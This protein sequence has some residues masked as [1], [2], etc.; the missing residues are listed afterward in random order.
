MN[1][2]LITS[3]N[4]RVKNIQQVT[5]QEK[6]LYQQEVVEGNKI[7]DEVVINQTKDINRGLKSSN[8]K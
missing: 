4:S 3:N 6:I 2:L 5:W 7:L 8:I 1:C